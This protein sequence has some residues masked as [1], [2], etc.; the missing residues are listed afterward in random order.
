M[1]FIYSAL[2]KKM[3]QNSILDISLISQELTA[4]KIVTISVILV[5][6]YVKP[7]S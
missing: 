5:S 1:K 7:I 4:V 2:F 6:D 3:F